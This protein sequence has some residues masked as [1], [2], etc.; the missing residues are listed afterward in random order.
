MGNSFPQ[1]VTKMLM[2]LIETGL[3]GWHGAC[4]LVRYNN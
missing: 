4:T 2:R 3:T 1:G